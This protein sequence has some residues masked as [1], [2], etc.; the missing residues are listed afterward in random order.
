MKKD[1]LQESWIFN[2]ALEKSDGSKCERLISED[3]MRKII[4]WVEEQD[5]QIGGGYRPP[6][7]NE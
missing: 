6:D 1:D 7:E 5:C 2:F 4:N 3:L